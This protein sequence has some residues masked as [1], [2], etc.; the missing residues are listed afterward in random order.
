MMSFFLHIEVDSSLSPTEFRQ[1][2]I[3][4]LQDALEREAIGHLL[5]DEPNRDDA[6]AGVY[7]LALEVS[8]QE[9]AREVVEQVLKSVDGP[10]EP[11]PAP[12]RC[13]G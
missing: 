7:E 2:V 10:V 3:V 9:R 6:P 8:D 5:D 13:G 11:G 12:D 1:R 4:P